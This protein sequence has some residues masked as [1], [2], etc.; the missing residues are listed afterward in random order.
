VQTRS[1]AATA[2]I[3]SRSTQSSSG[4]SRATGGSSRL[5]IPA[6]SRCSRLPMP[7]CQQ[8]MAATSSA[9]WTSSRPLQQQR[10]CL[11]QCCSRHTILR[12]A[13]MQR[14]HQL[15]LRLRQLCSPTVG[16]T[17]PPL[18][19]PP[20]WMT[21]APSSTAST[22]QL[23][24]AVWCPPPGSPHQ[25]LALNLSQAAAQ[26][27]RR[28]HFPTVAPVPQLASLL[29]WVTRR[30][31]QPLSR[32]PGS[33]PRQQQQLCH[34]RPAARR[35]CQSSGPLQQTRQRGCCRTSAR[36]LQRQRRRRPR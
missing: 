9:P 6:R 4:S 13:T 1:T 32:L 10:Q 31:R 30:P 12:P 8:A 19:S 33:Q 5:A 21:V 14:L 15:S 11:L 34:C 18:L 24:R 27:L 20:L 2:A 25:A 36:R 17:P 16:A 22:A 26:P 28:R 23:R 29:G 3:S 35:R 7:R